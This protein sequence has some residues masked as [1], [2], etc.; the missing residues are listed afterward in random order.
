MQLPPYSDLL[1]QYNQPA[2]II[3]QVDAHV[4]LY[5]DLIDYEDI[6]TPQNFKMFSSE[7]EIY[8]FLRI[9]YPEEVEKGS[10]FPFI[11]YIPEQEKFTFVTKRSPLIPLTIN[12]EDVLVLDGSLRVQYYYEDPENPDETIVVER[13]LGEEG[14]KLEDLLSNVANRPEGSFLPTPDLIQL[15]QKI[16]RPFLEGFINTK[17]IDIF[18]LLT[19]VGVSPDVTEELLNKIPQRDVRTRLLYDMRNGAFVMS[20]YR[21]KEGFFNDF[22]TESYLDIFARQGYDKVEIVINYDKLKPLNQR[23]SFKNPFCT[24]G[25]I[26]SLVILMKLLRK[27]TKNIKP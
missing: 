6:E 24:V 4:P 27:V 20:F 5:C 17:Y 2:A 21:Y 22:N 12:E 19:G 23:L 25:G 11:F 26:I 18:N 7:E 15:F 13:E 16:R 8:E 3:R 10:L 14:T 9:R 1:A